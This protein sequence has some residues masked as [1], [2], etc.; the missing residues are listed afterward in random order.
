MGFF[1][2]FQ[3]QFLFK[4][5]NFSSISTRK[6]T[7][8][9]RKFYGVKRLFSTLLACFSGSENQ[10][11]YDFRLLVQKFTSDVFFGFLEWIMCLDLHIFRFRFVYGLY[12][13]INIFKFAYKNMMFRN[14]N[15][16]T[17]QELKFMF[18]YLNLQ[19]YEYTFRNMHLFI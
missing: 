17:I 18:T 12:I 11:F 15:T 13:Q 6:S 16:Q 14:L 5:H 7:F 3:K 10:I 1:F 9:W 2:L 4:N 8:S 19:H